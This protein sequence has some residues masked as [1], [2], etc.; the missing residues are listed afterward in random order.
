MSRPRGSADRPASSGLLHHD[1]HTPSQGG[2]LYH[3]QEPSSSRA[4]AVFFEEMPPLVDFENDGLPSGVR[5]RRVFR[6]KASDPFQHRARTNTEHLPQRVHGDTVT[7][8]EHGQR[9]LPQGSPAW[10]GACKLIATAPIEPALCA[11]G[12]P[13]L[14]HGR[15]RTLRTC[16]HASPPPSA[17]VTMNRLGKHN[18]RS[19]LRQYSPTTMPPLWRAPG[20]PG[21]RPI[22]SAE[23]PGCAPASLYMASSAGDSRR[24]TARLSGW[25]SRVDA[26]GEIRAP[27]LPSWRAGLL[28][29]SRDI[30][31]LR[32]SVPAPRYPWR[33]GMGALVCRQA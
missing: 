9:L 2:G 16:R 4:C 24:L 3:D 14:D 26:P 20:R 19:L 25:R 32:P 10:C 23:P 22:T 29:L 27:G 30:P 17:L 15:M 33:P 6:G 5:F 31:L 8:E 7:I 1:A 21:C 12:F 13:G 11:L 28:V 18:S